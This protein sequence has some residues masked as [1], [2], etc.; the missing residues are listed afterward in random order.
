[1]FKGIVRLGDKLT[2]GGEVTSASSSIIVDGIPAA[3]VGDTVYCPKERHGVNKIVEGNE[4][5][6]DQ[7]N[8]AFHNCRCECGCS[9]ISS[10]TDAV[11]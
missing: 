7:Q 10:T 11:I 6:V 3:M 9:V 2:S 4:K 1:M 5:W 8:I